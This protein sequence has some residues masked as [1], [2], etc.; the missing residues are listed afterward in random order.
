MRRYLIQPFAFAIL[1]AAP[2]SEATAQG[3]MTHPFTQQEVFEGLR[4]FFPEE[5]ARKLAA[6]AAVQAV[7]PKDSAASGTTPRPEG[8]IDFSQDVL[9]VMSFLSEE[10][11]AKVER[12]RRRGGREPSAEE[13][14]AWERRRIE[15][16]EWA[17]DGYRRAPER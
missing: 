12:W 16:Q 15:L 14:R 1:T 7:A 4:R 9:I 17:K 2:H 6:D 11:R 10:T 3:R 13:Q 5:E 8:A